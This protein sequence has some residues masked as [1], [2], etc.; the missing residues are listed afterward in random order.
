MKNIFTHWKTS[1][2]GIILIATGIAAMMA[3]KAFT[4]EGLTAILG[5]VGLLMGADASSTNT[6]AGGQ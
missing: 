3:A 5:G 4:V 1:S 2:A 6:P